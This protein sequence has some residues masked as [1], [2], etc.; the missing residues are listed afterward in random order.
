M[1]PNNDVVLNN[2]SYYL[3]LRK[4]NLD[5]AE[6]MSR[7]VVQRNPTNPTYLDTFAWVL[8]QQGK[9]TE[10]KAIMEL[11]LGNGGDQEA[12]LLEHYGD[13]LWKSGEK[14][15]ALEYWK[16]AQ[17]MEYSGVSKFLN[18]KIDTQTLIDN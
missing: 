15:H 5:E 16:K 2:F 10:A 17:A 7:S 18:E 13:I 3:S 14:E 4:E 8:Y 12:I 1:E 9:Y 11:A 6:Q